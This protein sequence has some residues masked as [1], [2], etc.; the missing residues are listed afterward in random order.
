[1][2]KWRPPTIPADNEWEVI[3]QIVVP[4][5]YRS[6]VLSLAHDLPVA[7]HLGVGKTCD[8]ILKHFYWPN[9]RQTVANFCRTCHV[10][11][12]VGKPNQNP[13]KAPLSPI[14]AF[15]EPFSKV[16]VDC[17]GP[18]P[19]TKKGCEY[20]LTIICSSTRYPEA[21][22]LRSIKAKPVVEA[23]TAFF[24][25]CGLPKIVQSD[26][27]SNFTSK[28]FKEQLSALGVKHVT[29]SAYHPQSQGALERF[30]QTLKSMI[31]TYCLDHNKDWDEG[32]P[33]LLLIAIR[34]VV[35]ESLGFSPF[36]LVFGHTVR[37]P[38]TLVKEKWLHEK[39]T[40]N[41]LSHIIRLKER[42]KA[43]REFANVNLKATQLEM[44]TWYDRKSRE[45]SFS[46]GD[47]VLVLLPVSGQPLQARF[48]GP[49]VIDC[50]VG[51]LDYIVLTPDRRKTKQLCHINMLKPYHE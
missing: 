50:K 3:D 45:R 10:C 46:P 49:Y 5:P 40:D 6:H 33:L 28:M 29:S 24:T 47:K 42:L 2:R 41:V 1:M 39:S 21:I 15:E 31:R 32:L 19:K 27:G 18:L 44:K 22:P 12:V 26:Q 48:I 37:G 38:L 35:N 30:H 36:E 7:G 43:V 17:V 25:R 4:Q 13:P 34:E 11:Q 16:I 8:R 14:P 9:L 51:N 20:I 23:L